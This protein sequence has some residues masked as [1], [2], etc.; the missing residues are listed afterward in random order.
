MR[1]DKIQIQ[2]RKRKRASCL[3]KFY[4]KYNQ[5]AWT[6]PRWT[7]TTL[8]SSL[9]KR[10][11]FLTVRILQSAR[12]G[13]K[14]TDFQCLLARAIHME[15]WVQKASIEK[16]GPFVMQTWQHGI[17]RRKCHWLSIMQQWW[18][19]KRK[20]KARVVPHAKELEES[21]LCGWRRWIRTCTW[22]ESV[23]PLQSAAITSKQKFPPLCKPHRILQK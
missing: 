5:W 17:R 10:E 1:T 13:N 8:L 16:V 6:R 9:T 18:D 11:I 2:K 19:P 22:G 23:S 20:S 12:K 15:M 21:P 4:N 3:N 14:C 7:K